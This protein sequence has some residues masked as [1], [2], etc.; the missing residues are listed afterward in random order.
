VTG[1]ILAL[2][3]FVLL[4]I[5]VLSGGYT[6]YYL[7]QWQWVRA[8][9]AG[10]T[11]VATLVVGAT[12]LVLARI[13]RLARDINRRL[14]MLESQQRAR[15]DIPRQDG[16]S[17]RAEGSH[18]DFPWLSPSFAP[19]R[20]QLLLPVVVAGMSVPALE[21][22]RVGV[23]IPVLLGAGLA[24]S[25]IAGLIERVAASKGVAA[26][27]AHGTTERF[28]VPRL[29]A[30]GAAVV[31]V[32]AVATAALYWAA[33]Y[34]PAPLGDGTTE[35]SVQVSV[36]D[37]LSR[38]TETV[39]MMARYCAR[40]AIFGVRVERVEPESAGTALLVVSPL[41]DEEAQRRFGG[42]LEDANLDRHR[43]VV[44]ETALVPAEGSAE[45][46]G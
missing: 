10:I 27:P 37:R 7:Y 23:F 18:H 44:T 38:P 19:Q 39:E 26:R 35:M 6:V 40:N 22:A 3:R 11:F 36:K 21:S 32:I 13:D 15:L 25:I 1:F 8:Q 28:P 33:H 31:A 41:L 29:A 5:T 20:R 24:V 45:P 30:R 4:C 14:D 16:S 17:G 34:R 43:L 12:I 42:C 2:G 46:A 9:I